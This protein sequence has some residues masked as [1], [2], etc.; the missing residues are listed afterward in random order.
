MALVW[1]VGSGGLLGQALVCKIVKTE[2]VLFDPEVKFNWNNLGI[3]TEQLKQITNQFALQVAKGPWK[4]YWAAGTST[5]HSTEKALQEETYILEELVSTLLGDSNLNLSAGTFIFAS[6]AGA[7]YAGVCDEVITESTA[8]APVNAYGR[9]KLLQES[10]VNKL[11]GNGQGVTIISCRISTLY[12]FKSKSGKQQGLIA[13]MIRRSLSNQV[14]HIYVPLETMRDYISAKNAAIQMIKTTALLEKT[15]GPHLKIIAS[16][17]STSVAQILAILKQIC[18]L[19]LRVVTQADTKSRQYQRVV[20]FQS[21]IHI[22]THQKDGHNLIESISDLL[23]T[24]QK[25]I[26]TNGIAS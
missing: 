26:A 20:Q 3:A 1:V 22:S 21:E 17:V 16:G 11:N 24:I 18:K 6:S 14:V 5:M 9:A 12:G 23:N 7:I 4:I 8:P 19:N 15:P 25:D 10:L 2:D 13:E